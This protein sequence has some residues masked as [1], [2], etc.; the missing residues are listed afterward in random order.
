[1]A[2]TVPPSTATPTPTSSPAVDAYLELLDGLVSEAGFADA[3]DQAQDLFVSVGER[4]CRLFDLGLEIEDL[5]TVSLVTMGTLEEDGE[6]VALAGIVLGAAVARLCPRHLGLLE[7][8][9]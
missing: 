3:V 5:L 4:M 2:A 6:Q 7:A 8:D 9:G 1:M